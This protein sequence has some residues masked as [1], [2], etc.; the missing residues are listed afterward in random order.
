MFVG[1]KNLGWRSATAEAI[2]LTPVVES[3]NFNSGIM[4]SCSQFNFVKSSYEIRMLIRK[5]SIKCDWN[6]NAS[7]Q[8]IMF[9]IL[10]SLQRISRYKRYRWPHLYRLYLE[11]LC[12]IGLLLPGR[13]LRDTPWLHSCRWGL[14]VLFPFHRPSLHLSPNCVIFW[15]SKAN[16]LGMPVCA[17]MDLLCSW[18]CHI[19]P[20]I[21]RRQLVR[22]AF[23]L[24]SW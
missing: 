2:S 14:Q 1:E 12:I 6:Q 13:T 10:W 24:P 5:N 3:N 23:S 18:S 16:M 11:I 20:M 21:Y 19:M 8:T 9:H 17:K 4:R 7:F 22:K 15:A